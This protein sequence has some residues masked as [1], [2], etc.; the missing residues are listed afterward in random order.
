MQRTILAAG[1]AALS[2]AAGLAFAAG[3][4]TRDPITPYKP[5]FAGQTRAPEQKLGVA[6]ETTTVATGLRFPWSIAF[7][8]D[9]RMLVTE[10]A[11]AL[12]IVGQD[13]KVS[14]PVAGTPQ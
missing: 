1:T 2:L 6:F 12:R 9:G 5:A 10:K 8:P 11:G 3:V 13:G 14:E 4:E 7:L